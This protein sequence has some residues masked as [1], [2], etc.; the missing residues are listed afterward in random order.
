MPIYGLSPGFFNLRKI[1]TNKKQKSFIFN[2]KNFLFISKL[3]SLVMK[4]KALTENH[5]YNFLFVSWAY[6]EDFLSNGEYFDRYFKISS[7]HKKILWL[8]IF[9]GRNI[10]KKI[11]GNILIIHNKK[12]F[13]KYN[14]FFLLNYFLTTIIRNRLDF[15]NIFH[16]LR[17]ETCFALKI[18]S[19][20]K[21]ILSK[22]KIDRLYLPYE[23]QT[24]QNQIILTAKTCNKRIK[25]YG[26]EHTLV[27]LPINNIY[28]SP[29]PDFLYIHSHAQK[30]IYIKFL[31]WPKKKIINIPSLRFL[32]KGK[33]FFDQKIFL[34]NNILSKEELVKNFEIFLNYFYSKKIKPFNNVRIHPLQKESKKH[35]LFKKEINDLIKNYENIFSNTSKHSYSVFFGATSSVIEALE[36][37]SNVI[38]IVDNATFETY[39]SK[40]WPSINV[41]MINKN[42]FRYTLKTKK[43][44]ITF[45]NRQRNFNLPNFLPKV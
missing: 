26:Y 34:P 45:G 15:K 39:S 3:S 31:K 35:N 22:K 4:G 24:F 19:F 11:D 21:K 37:G 7:K 18:D 13:F 5:K 41:S 1:E 32:K 17:Q 28:K 10:P 42:I 23:S 38:H 30:N 16:Q 44:C 12:V 20:L 27:S 9:M 43:K 25:I 6:E 2:L 36:N 33:Q 40:L 14:L 29:S 8:L